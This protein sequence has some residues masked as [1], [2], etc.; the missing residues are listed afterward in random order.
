MTDEEFQRITG[1]IKSAVDTAREA[2]RQDVVE[3]LTPI[4]EDIKGLKG[5]VFNLKGDVFNLKGA[6]DSLTFRMTSLESKVENGFA[7]LKKM[8]QGDVGAAFDDIEK[9]KKSDERLRRTS[10]DY[11]KRITALE[12]ARG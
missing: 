8:E 3:E 9:L 4:R 12:E 5:D 11:E 6:V 2:F 1:F 7:K 10:A